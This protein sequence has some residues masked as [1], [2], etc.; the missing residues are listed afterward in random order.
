[1]EGKAVNRVHDDRHSG[2]LSGKATNKPCFGVVGVNHMVRSSDEMG[3][4][5]EDRQKILQR[6]EG[7]HQVGEGFY[8]YSV[9]LN[10]VN[11]CSSGR[12]GKDR[13]IAV[14]LHAL[15]GEEGID[16][17]S[18]DDGQRVYVE[19]PDHR[20][21]ALTPFPGRD[22]GDVHNLLNEQVF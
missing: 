1:V 8:F 2:E 16:P 14:S 21:V 5:V 12:A 10:Q 7:L 11:E 6:V 15:H 17:R 20:L 22:P 13:F 9:P 4:K 18:T 3:G 19:D